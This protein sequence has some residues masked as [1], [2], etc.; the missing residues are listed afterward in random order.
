MMATWGIIGLLVCSIVPG[1]ILLR[2]TGCERILPN[3]SGPFALSLLLN[4][5]FVQLVVW[6][7]I[8]TPEFVRP[9]G[10]VLVLLAWGFL[11]TDR[12]LVLSEVAG[13]TR[14]N[15]AAFTA[16]GTGRPLAIFSLILLPFIIWSISQTAGKDAGTLITGYDP[17]AQWNLWAIDWGSN[18]FPNRIYHYPQLLPIAWSIPY[19]FMGN[20][21]VQLFSSALKVFFWFGILETLLFISLKLGRPALF[22]SFPLAYMYFLRCGHSTAME[23]YV[24]VPVSFMAIVSFGAIVGRSTGTVSRG[25]LVVAFAIAS[26]TAMTKQ[27]GLYMIGA[28]PLVLMV[29]RFETSR[30][31]R[32]AIVFGLRM[33]PLFILALVAA[34]SM[35]VYAELTI[36]N[37]TNVSAFSYLFDEVY[38]A[39]GTGTRILVALK[40]ISSWWWLTALT[41]A[42]GA[43][44]LADR[45]WRWPMPLIVVPF[46][47]SWLVF[48]SYDERNLSLIACFL[49]LS[50]AAGVNII[51]HNLPDWQARTFP[52]F[53]RYGIASVTIAITAVAIIL[54]SKTPA[55][56]LVRRQH[57]LEKEK[58]ARDEEG[59]LISKIIEDIVIRHPG[60]AIF[61]DWRWACQYNF[62]R[63][64]PCHRLLKPSLETIPEQ[65]PALLILFTRNV[66]ADIVT[67]L[68]DHGYVETRQ[69]LPLKVSFY[70][71]EAR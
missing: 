14:N 7:G 45:T 18:H 35:Y 55:S 1:Y 24:D 30:S 47:V 62:T 65:T 60:L 57:D 6:L 9:L 34:S 68:L 48:F 17:V 56:D 67:S 46:F 69:G 2:V 21:E 71:K 33:I 64:L 63:A 22:L 23:D 15:V 39:N 50:V 44:S 51:V 32:E 13:R 54:T 5:L 61:S 66:S 36:R 29:W 52:R 26:G 27:V 25:D 20:I 3:F 10:V 28:I 53:D 58:L 12:R 11:L 4:C 16:S 70:L 31:L 19:A 37:G 40:S 59:P 49:G 42:G 38:E 8:Y 41:V 43:A